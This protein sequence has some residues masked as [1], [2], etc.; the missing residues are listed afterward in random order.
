MKSLKLSC[1]VMLYCKIR[2][3]L[4][5]FVMQ[6]CNHLSELLS[7]KH[8]TEPQRQDP[9]SLNKKVS[10]R[11]ENNETGSLFLRIKHFLEQ[12]TKILIRQPS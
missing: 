1:V 6:S 7:F 5:Y 2:T 11:A 3:K 8:Y 12:P 4:F 10:K 9:F